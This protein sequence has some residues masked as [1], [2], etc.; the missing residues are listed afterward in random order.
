MVES[1]ASI[2]TGFGF[3]AARTR[4]YFTIGTQLNHERNF[5]AVHNYVPIYKTVIKNLKFIYT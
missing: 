1:Y 4:Y 3:P 2:V 5:S